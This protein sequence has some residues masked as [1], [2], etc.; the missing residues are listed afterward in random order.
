MENQKKVKKT[1]EEL[2]E[3]L[4]INATVEVKT[5]ED[6]EPVIE[7]LISSESEAGLLIGAHGST[8]LAIQSFLA[9]SLK[10]ETGEWV[11]IA[12]DVDG[13]KDKQEDYLKDLATQAA[14]RAKSTGQA[15]N[16]YNLNSNQRRIVHT[17]LSEIEGVSTESQGEGEGRYLVVKP[18]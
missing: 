2:L 4:G 7:V 12:V 15:Q 13:W 6:K 10:Q 8:L 5:T 16:L 9:L 11:R 17:V 3:L 1:A 18:E 14:D